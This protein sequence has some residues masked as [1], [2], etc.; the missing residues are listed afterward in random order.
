MN[1]VCLRIPYSINGVKKHSLQ[2]CNV[3]D[4][5]SLISKAIKYMCNSTEIVNSRL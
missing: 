1:T 2:F 3:N 4:I 5:F